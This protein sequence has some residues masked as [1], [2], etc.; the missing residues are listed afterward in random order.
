MRRRSGTFLLCGA[1]TAC[2]FA[3]TLAA[4]ASAS[5][6]WKI[7]GSALGG[8]ETARAEAT[9]GTLIVPGLTT[10][11][12]FPFEMTI[13]NTAGTAHGEVEAFPLANCTTNGACTVE[14]AGAENLPWPLHGATVKTN[15]YVIF[16][17]VRLSL[18]YEGPFCPIAET[19]VTFQGSAGGLFNN[20]THSFSF[21]SAT[22][23]TTKTKLSAFGTAVEW[24]G[25]FPAEATGA[26]AGLGL[27]L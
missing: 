5:P 10:T 6:A 23:A 12:D 16:E 18:L 13:W 11:C 8:T 20:L 25:V 22:F 1:A 9:E 21:S 14:S 27:E 2:V 3:A 24:N 15:N 4:S 19:T 26:N 17:G 7:G